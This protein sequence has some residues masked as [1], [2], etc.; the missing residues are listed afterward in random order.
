MSSKRN[1]KLVLNKE[2]MKVLSD[3]QLEKPAGGRPR[4]TFRLYGCDTATSCG[5]YYCNPSNLFSDCDRVI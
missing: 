3:S 1:K 4:G 5:L 2:T